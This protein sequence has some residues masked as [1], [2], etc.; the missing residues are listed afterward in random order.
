MKKSIFA[1]AAAATS[2][3]LSSCFQN[4]TTIH[5]NKDGSGT[6]V[7]ETRLGAQ[8]LGM[9]DQMAALGGGADAPDPLKEIFS[10]AKAKK[11][12]AELGEGVT[13]AKSEPLNGGGGKGARVT[14]QC[15][16]INTL[17][18]STDDGMRSV[19]SM[20]P[21]GAAQV[22]AAPKSEPVQFSYADG[23]LTIK[24][25]EPK[26]D[27]D[28]PEVPAGET[29]EMPDLENPQT[30]EMMKQMFTDMK[31]SLKLVIE[32]GIAETNASHKDGDTI[33]LMEMNMGKLMENADNIKKLGKVDQK[34]P[35]AAMEA[36]KNIPGVTIETAKEVTVTVK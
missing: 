17:K 3:L 19:S 29:P 4:E 10:E 27:P 33:T 18:V 7:E 23:K 11:R 1:V 12:A 16:D 5:L 21:M 20:S 35:A 14:Y 6:L 31:M 26:V 9:L 15:K 22:A 28:A 8:M 36:L 25:P 32:P 24:M 30:Q 34:N 2:L 13:Y